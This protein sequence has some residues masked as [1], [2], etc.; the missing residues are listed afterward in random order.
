MLMY[1]VIHISS[2]IKFCKRTYCFKDII[3]EGKPKPVDVMF[4]KDGERQRD[5]LRDI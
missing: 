4:S 2:M 1:R 5:R 3:G